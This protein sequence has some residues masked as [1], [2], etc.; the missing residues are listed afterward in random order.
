MM[1]IPVHDI[2]LS[3]HHFVSFSAARIKK[4]ERRKNKEQ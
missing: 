3:F 4:E 1:K 2:I